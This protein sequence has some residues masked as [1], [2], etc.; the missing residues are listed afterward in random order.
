MPQKK[1]GRAKGRQCRAGGPKEKAE[2]TSRRGPAQAAT[3]PASGQ[4]L[5]ASAAAARSCRCVRCNYLRMQLLRSYCTGSLQSRKN[6]G[7]RRRRLGAA[8]SVTANNSLHTHGGSAG[9]GGGGGVVSCSQQLPAQRRRRSWGRGS[10]LGMP[11][12]EQPRRCAAAPRGLR[13]A[14][15]TVRRCSPSPQPHPQAARPAVAHVI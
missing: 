14:S 8:S 12:T 4:A 13:Q 15:P 11:A 3:R 2:N 1:G 9:G 5:Q 6:T 7:H 10:V